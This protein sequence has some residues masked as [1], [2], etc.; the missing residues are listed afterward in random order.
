VFASTYVNWSAATVASRLRA[1]ARVSVGQAHAAMALEASEVARDR[2]LRAGGIANAGAVRAIAPIA[3]RAREYAVVTRERTTASHDDAYRALEPEWHV[4][5]AT[6]TRTA[7][8]LW[9]LSG[10]RPES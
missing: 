7:R 1:L 2:A 9:V 8:G 10:W 6:V 3:G 5:L 4:T